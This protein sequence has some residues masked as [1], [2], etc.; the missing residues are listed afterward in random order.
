ML[1]EVKVIINILGSKVLMA[2]HFK[3]KLLILIKF[4][5]ISDIQSTNNN[6]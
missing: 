1:L 2:F 3:I 6:V 5:A 4:T